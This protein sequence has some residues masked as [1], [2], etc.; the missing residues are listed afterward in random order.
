[1]IQVRKNVFETNSSSTHSLVMCT[2]SEYEKWAKG[3]IYYCDW[4]PYK[5]DESLKKKDNFYTEEEAKAI[6]ESAGISWDAEDDDC[7][8]RKEYFY[9]LDEFCDSDYLEVE[10]YSY[11]TPGGEIIKAI[12]KYG[13]NG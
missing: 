10:E 8:E 13:Y 2:S 5:A 12:A 6:C 1:M 9:T 7:C 11:T 3:E 4:L